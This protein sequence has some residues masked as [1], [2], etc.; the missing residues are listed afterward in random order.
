M[1]VINKNIINS[2]LAAAAAFVSAIADCSAGDSVAMCISA[3][4]VS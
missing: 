2:P 4:G 1:T 3:P